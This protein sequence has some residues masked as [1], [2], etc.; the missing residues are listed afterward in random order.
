MRPVNLSI[1]GLRLTT[2]TVNASAAIPTQISFDALYQRAKEAREPAARV[3]GE[4]R[5]VGKLLA[6]AKQAADAG[7]MNK[8]RQPAEPAKTHSKLGY[9]QAIS[10]R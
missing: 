5:D 3:G 1:S 9:R 7:D 6:D 4:W 2:A 10:Q 8:A